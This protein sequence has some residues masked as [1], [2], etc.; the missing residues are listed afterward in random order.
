M[1]RAEILG[2][3]WGNCKKTLKGGKKRGIKGGRK[4]STIRE[5]IRGSD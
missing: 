2:R 3:E 1:G 5:G 4:G